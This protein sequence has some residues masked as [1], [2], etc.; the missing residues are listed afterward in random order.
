[1]T[2]F[3]ERFQASLP[4]VIV[5]LSTVVSIGA[6]AP[7][8]LDNHPGKAI[9]QKLCLECHGPHGEGAEDIDVDPLV[10]KRTLESL[11]GRIERTMPE[12]NEDAC[13]GP[14]AEAVAEYIYHAFYSLEAQA[15]LQP[16]RR[17][18]SRLTGP[19]FLGSSSDLIAS[20]FTNQGH[21][22]IIEADRIGLKGNYDL[23]NRSR[24]GN[25]DFE[26]ERFDRV[27]PQ[28]RF[29]YGKGIPEVP[30]GMR[31]D[32]TQFNITWRGSIFAPETGTYEFTLRT[33]NGAKLY[34]NELDD[35][36]EP[37]ID[38]WVAPDNRIREKSGRVELLGGRRYYIRL[39]FFKYKE[40]QAL[41][42]LIWEKP[43]GRREVVPASMLTHDW[44]QPVFVGT[45]PM[46]ADDRSMGY[47]RGTS[48][49]RVWFDAVTSN[50]FQ[51]SDFVARHIDRLAKTKDGDPERAKKLRAFAEEFTARAY[52][53]PLKPGEREKAVDPHFA[54]AD[55]PD[56][57]VR[58]VVL[59]ALTSPHFLYP[60]TAFDSPNGPWARAS[61][62]S[63]TL[64]DS[65]PDKRLRD[66]AGKNRLRDAKELEKEAWRMLWDGRARYKVKGFF[67]HWLELARAENVAKDSTL[68]PQF[69]PE[70]MAD[71]RTSLDLYLDDVVWSEGAA[72]YRQLLLADY[73]YLNPRLGKIYGKPD[74]KGGFQKVSFKGKG[75]TGVITHPFLLTAFAYHNNTS[76]IHRG[77]FL[78]RN[79]VG[80]PLKP[81]TEA[82][83]FEDS[84]F[85]PNLTMREKVTQMT[86]AK[87]CMA[88]HSTI[89]PLG[90]SLEHYDALGRWRAKERN[91]PIDDNSVLET[92]GGD[93][94]EIGGP[95]DVAKY[96]ASSPDAHHAFVQ[97]LF[98]H[99]VKQPGAVFGPGTLER[100]ENEFRQNG[101]DI[102]TL[103]VRIAATSAQPPSIDS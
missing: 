61:A 54:E 66:T 8:D 72:D 42:E 29:D 37:T 80:L 84:K 35:K 90:F 30:D 101:F 100:L 6:A 26:R 56:D 17:D 94:I 46:P 4:V 23:N 74:L 16:V 78:T 33:R 77:V 11:A 14:D 40:E 22:P 99:A 5:A 92:D 79:I 63:L 48:V 103:L 50:A 67:H 27:D 86:R 102:R 58:G 24:A 51:A 13:V 85:P 7:I 43:T 75:R 96:A 65:L 20:F 89:N 97:A 25:N 59:A 95:H 98:H 70:V 1:M 73:L 31:T 71:L 38:A 41:I 21:P 2:Q 18:L 47:E 34:V 9:Y 49:S 82:I 93:R 52:R 10:G 81:P 69:S 53:R 88:C 28:I 36:Q 62:L 91:K 83:E 19:Q 68:Y 39:D 15:R 76:P 12:D 44:A 32:L 3:R 64:W 60:E 57:A 45:T 87:A 55:E